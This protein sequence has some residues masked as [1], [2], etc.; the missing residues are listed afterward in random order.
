MTAHSWWAQ[1]WT[2]APVYF[3]LLKGLFN[4]ACT[5]YH[6][7]CVS[8]V[9]RNTQHFWHAYCKIYFAFITEEKFKLDLV[10]SNVFSSLWHASQHQF[11]SMS[12]SLLMNSGREKLKLNSLTVFSYALQALATESYNTPQV[13][14]HTET[15]GMHITE[16]KQVGTGT[17]GCPVQMPEQVDSCWRVV[18]W[19]K[20]HIITSHLH[21]ISAVTHTYSTTS[22]EQIED[23][24]YFP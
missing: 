14:Q 12:D 23:S 21:W 19:R 7:N 22:R 1:Y 2:Q 13:S 20:L 6:S 15:H 18:F 9:T 17:F 11:M 10:I 4:S 8:C 5:T 3:I 24:V 16:G